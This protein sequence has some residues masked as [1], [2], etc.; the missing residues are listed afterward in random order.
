MNRSDDTFRYWFTGVEYAADTRTGAHARIKEVPGGWSWRISDND[1][2][3]T[4][5]GT[6]TT[7]KGARAAC[8]KFVR[9]LPSRTLT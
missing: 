1:G 3:V 9:K 7:Q 6:S 5:R 8:R 2:V 4:M